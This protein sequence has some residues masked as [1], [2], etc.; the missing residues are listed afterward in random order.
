MMN[1]RSCKSPYGINFDLGFENEKIG[2][3]HLCEADI[4]HA[5]ARARIETPSDIDLKGIIN[6]CMLCI[7][8]LA[9]ISKG[10]VVAA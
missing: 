5:C 6:I 1:C 2:N 9:G 10:R 8:S 3:C 4:C 7:K